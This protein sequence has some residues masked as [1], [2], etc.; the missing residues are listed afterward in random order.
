MT[1]KVVGLIL[2]VAL[3]SGITG[4]IVGVS[5]PTVMAGDYDSQI[6]RELKKIRQILNPNHGRY[7]HSP[8][9]IGELKEMK[10]ILDSRLRRIEA[11]IEN[12]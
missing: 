12:Q 4:F 9:V 5:A 10:E 11:A 2:L 3:V 6:A 1:K 8:S 7:T